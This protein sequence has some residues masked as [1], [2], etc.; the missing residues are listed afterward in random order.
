MDD[1][2]D[3]LA[4]TGLPRDAEPYARPPLPEQ[5]LPPPSTAVERR[6]RPCPVPPAI[7]AELDVPLLSTPKYPDDPALQSAHTQYVFHGRDLLAIAGSVNLAPA[8]LTRRVRE[9][10]WDDDRTAV[11]TAEREAVT[12]ALGRYAAAAALPFVSRLDSTSR[13][14]LQRVNDLLNDPDQ[15]TAARLAHLTKALKDVHDVG[16]SLLSMGQPDFKPDA[17]PG[18]GP[19]V[20]VNV[21]QA[22]QSAVKTAQDAKRVINVT[23]KPVPAT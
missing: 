13:L 17:A 15:V 2:N 22:A 23:P 19:A 4:I 8:E 6:A 9:D 18:T 12:Q 11:L 7:L 10:K 1:P 20:Q 16:L 5:E 14:A 3:T 21:L